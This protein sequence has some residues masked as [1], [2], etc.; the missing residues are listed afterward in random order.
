MDISRQ[1][2][3]ASVEHGQEAIH[4]QFL[5][6]SAV[7]LVKNRTYFKT[8]GRYYAKQVCEVSHGLAGNCMRV[9]KCM[10]VIV[11]GTCAFY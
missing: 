7:S 8:S 1:S 4:T 11:A 10:S 2:W 9:H 3:P 5:D 6:E